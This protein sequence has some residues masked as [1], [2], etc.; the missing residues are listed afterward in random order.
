MD[1]KVDA[2]ILELYAATFQEDNYPPVAGKILGLFYVSEQKYFSFEDLQS[3]IG[4]SKSAVSK[5]LKM[6]LNIG[7]INFVT[8][9]DNKRKRYFYLDIQGSIDRI[10][11]LMDSYLMQTELLQE[12]LA[13]RAETNPELNNFIANSIKFN[14]EVIAFV[15]QKVKEHY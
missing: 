11:R 8:F 15:E 4:I 12:T 2:H 6:L 3:L 10:Q 5:G 7:E 14:R 1:N 13:L 9:E